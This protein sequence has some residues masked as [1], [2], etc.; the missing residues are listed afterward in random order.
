MGSTRARRLYPTPIPCEWA[1]VYSEEKQTK[2]YRA[3]GSSTSDDPSREEEFDWEG[4]D[5]DY[6]RGLD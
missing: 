4:L 2:V 1:W 5:D 6:E 3:I